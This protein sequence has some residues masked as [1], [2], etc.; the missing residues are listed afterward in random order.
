MAAFEPFKKG[1]FAIRSTICLEPMFKE[2]VYLYEYGINS[3]TLKCDLLV[4]QG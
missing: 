3:E 2:F 1:N 4:K